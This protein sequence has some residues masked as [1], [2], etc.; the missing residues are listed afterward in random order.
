LERDPLQELPQAAIFW[1]CYRL[2][3]A[4]C[5]QNRFVFLLQIIILPPFG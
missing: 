2:R 5:P 1:H 3:K 4:A